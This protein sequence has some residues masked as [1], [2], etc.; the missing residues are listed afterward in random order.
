ML[1]PGR[2]VNNIISLYNLN[3][4]DLA[5][6]TYRYPDKPVPLPPGISQH[7]GITQQTLNPSW[8]NATET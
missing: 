5:G 4:T 8:N 1:Q 3:V 7:R 6:Y 2:R